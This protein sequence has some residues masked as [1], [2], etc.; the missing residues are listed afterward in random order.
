TT[1][2]DLLAATFPGGSITG[3]PKLRAMEI[4]AELETR[5]RGPYCGAIGWIGLDGN[6]DLNIAI[7][8][9]VC[10]EAKQEAR[11]FSG[12][13]IVVDSDPEKEYDETQLKAAAFYRALSM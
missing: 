4:I 8:T 7:R 2:G 9:A 6:L 12:A 13:G 5:A 11:Y 1:V 3:A 10:D